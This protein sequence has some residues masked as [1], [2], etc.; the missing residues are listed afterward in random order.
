MAQPRYVISTDYKEKTTRD[1]NNLEPGDWIHQ[2][3][4][5]LAR[6]VG[7]S[8]LEYCYFHYTLKIYWL[9]KFIVTTVD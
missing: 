7:W 3:D 9:S 1:A 8:R 6:E 2:A 4:C 5:W